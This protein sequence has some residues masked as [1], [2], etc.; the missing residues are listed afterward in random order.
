VQRRGAGI[1]KEA[2]MEIFSKTKFDNLNQKDIQHLIDNGVSE[3]KSLDY[4]SALPGNRDKDKKE[5]LADVSSFTNSIGGY[6]IFGVEEKEGIPQKLLGLENINPDQEILRLEG[7]IQNG[8][9]PRI[10]GINIRSIPFGSECNLIIIKIP[11]SWVSPHMV[12]FRGSSKFYARNS[13]GKYQL[14]VFEIGS[15]FSA[16][17]DTSEKI[18]SF[19]IDR[20]GKIISDDLPISLGSGASC[21][22]HLVPFGAFDSRNI[23]NL[24][25]LS[26]KRELLSPI[27]CDYGS[28]FRYNFDGVITTGPDSDSG[29]SSGY[30]QIFR[31]GIIEAVDRYLLGPRELYPGNLEDELIKSITKYFQIVKTLDISFPLIIMLSLLNV[32]NFPFRYSPKSFDPRHKETKVD[33]NEL[34]IPEIW[35]DDSSAPTDKI[36]RPAFDAI[37]NS[38]GWPKS[39]LYDEEGNKI[40]R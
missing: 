36:L 18:R 28:N 4:K 40:L 31:N 22:L 8:I 17:Y 26:E 15:A 39:Q 1:Y 3:S 35:V 2:N 13:A 6:I 33:R 27:Y 32:K 20:L 29:Y 38:A 12:T 16:T 34:I 5:F 7:I 25:P 37:W 9:S 11:R 21:V 14:D 30:L 19:R 23:Y 24:I 10:P